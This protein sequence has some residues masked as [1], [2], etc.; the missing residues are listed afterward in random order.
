MKK[1]DYAPRLAAGVAIAAFA[2]AVGTPAY[3]ATVIECPGANCVATDENVLLD[4]G[5]YALGTPATGITNQT[6]VGVTFTSLTDAL[7]ASSGQAS[8]SAVDGVLNQITFFL[9]PGS[10]FQTAEFNLA[11]LTGNNPLE[12]TSVSFLGIGG[13]IIPASF[14][15]S[16][17]GNNWFGVTAGPGDSLSGIQFTFAPGANGIDSLRQLRLGGVTSSTAVPEPATWAMLLFGFGGIGFALRRRKATVRR[18]RVAYT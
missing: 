11:P 17:N 10:T 14:G 6:N 2:L 12:A 1:L 18:L 15:L 5:T 3:A 13:T 16:G 7:I 8:L 4:G 9:A